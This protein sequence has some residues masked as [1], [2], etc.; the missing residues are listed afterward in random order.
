MRWCDLGYN[1]VLLLAGGIMF[2]V[3]PWSERDELVVAFGGAYLLEAMA[4][5][6][7]TRRV[8]KRP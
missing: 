5:R 7:L 2:F 3:L 1:A 4:Y 6:L 8:R